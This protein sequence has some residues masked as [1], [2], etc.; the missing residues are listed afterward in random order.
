[1]NQDTAAQ[2]CGPDTD[3]PGVLAMNQDQCN[4]FATCDADS[5]LGSALNTLEP[6]KVADVHTLSTQYT[7][8]GHL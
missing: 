1:M 4:I 6:L 2:E 3:M 8:N 7:R 5:P